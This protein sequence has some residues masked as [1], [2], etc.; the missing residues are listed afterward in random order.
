MFL[1]LGAVMVARYTEFR[2]NPKGVP[3]A[4][5]VMKTGVIA[6]DTLE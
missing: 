1:Q 6:P 4:E 5:L 3:R 2:G